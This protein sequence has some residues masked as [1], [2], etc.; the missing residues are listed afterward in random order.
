[1]KVSVII[2]TL[3]EALV[4]EESLTAIASLNPHEIIVADGGSTDNTVELASRIATRV[5][6]SKTGRA[7]QMNT[8]AKEATGQLLLFIHADS[9][10]SEEGYKKM[11][12]E[13]SL[14]EPAGGAFSL[15]IESKRLSLRL[16][17]KLATWRS[18]YLN[19]V[20]GDQAIFVR[21]DVFQ[22]LDGFSPLPIC[23]DL[24]FFRR[25]SQHGKVVLLNEKTHTSSRRWITEGVL[26][27]TF[28]NTIIAILFLLGFSP[29]FLNRWYLVVR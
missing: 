3:N 16:I 9:T 5:V 18:K 19:L 7:T 20:Y 29:H 28:R 10:L 13:M 6:A 25:L 1:M 14:L 11:T 26:F 8:G 22:I 12:R 4:I 21:S 2:P 15:H 17:S 23:E 24:E 27:T